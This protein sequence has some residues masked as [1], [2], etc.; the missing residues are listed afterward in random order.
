MKKIF[1]LLFSFYLLNTTLLIA[2]KPATI[3]MITPSTNFYKKDI[4]V[5]KNYFQ[6]HHNTVLIAS[7]K[8]K[9]L[10]DKT[11]QIIRPDLLFD[12][13]SPNDFDILVIIGGTGSEEYWTNHQVFKIIRD[14]KQQNKIICAQGLSVLVLGKAGILKDKKITAIPS[15]KYDLKKFGC[16]YIE[17]NIMEDGNI[18]T[19]K[20]SQNSLLF[21]KCIQEKFKENQK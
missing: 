13:V 7:T 15:L 6:K 21:A 16:T 9:P 2:Q 11:G 12:C 4:V 8:L 20:S 1:F 5:L 3:L 14:M 18:I 17:E 19:S 10:K